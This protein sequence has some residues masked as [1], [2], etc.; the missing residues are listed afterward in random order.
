MLVGVVARLPSLS[1]APAPS[2]DDEPAEQGENCSHLFVV[3]SPNNSYSLSLAS[4]SHSP[5]GAVVDS[6]I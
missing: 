6:I 5:V 4:H 3:N 2:L 1:P